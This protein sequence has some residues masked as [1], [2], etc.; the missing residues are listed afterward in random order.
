MVISYSRYV[1]KLVVVEGG[2]SDGDPLRRNCW[3]RRK[4]V[5]EGRADGIDGLRSGKKKQRLK[6][7]KTRE[8]EHVGK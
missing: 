3:E 2:D 8:L 5:V 1:L 7:E 6:E 4:P